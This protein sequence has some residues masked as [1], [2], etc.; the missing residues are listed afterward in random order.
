MSGLVVNHT[1]ILPARLVEN[2]H[3]VDKAG[4]HCLPLR[5]FDIDR[6]KRAVFGEGKL[7]IAGRKARD[8]QLVCHISDNAEHLLPVAPEQI[9]APLVRLLR[10]RHEFFCILVHVF[11]RNRADRILRGLVEAALRH[12]VAYRAFQHIVGKCPEY[13]RVEACLPPRL[14]FQPIA[15]EKRIPA[16]R[17]LIEP[18]RR[19]R[20]LPAVEPLHRLFG[21]CG[22][23][24]DAA[25][26]QLPAHL[27]THGVECPVRLLPDCLRAQRPPVRQ[28]ACVLPRK[29]LALRKK[30]LRSCHQVRW[31]FTAGQK[32]HT[33]SRALQR[34]LRPA[35]L[36]FEP[37]R[38]KQ[39]QLHTE[40]RQIPPVAVR[41]Q[42]L[43][44]G[45]RR[46][47][48]LVCT[49]DN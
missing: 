44:L 41:Q 36:P 7:L 26:F 19:E 31:L 15:Q 49:E 3:P 18:G 27:Q 23:G 40:A 20:K 38:S 32:P 10:V 11:L 8:A 30:R 17:K 24:K 43:R 6:R 29:R 16:A 34:Q 28:K 33:L 47:R 25:P 21:K 37:V 22:K 2:I 13:R 4:Q 42:P 9:R 48:A 1:E 12:H 14:Q 39:R 45:K 46:K 35:K 5:R